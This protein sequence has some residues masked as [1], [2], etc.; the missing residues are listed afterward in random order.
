VK[1]VYSFCSNQRAA[2]AFDDFCL[3]IT[4]IIQLGLPQGLPFLPIL[5][6]LF[7]SDLLIGTINVVEGDMGFVDDYTA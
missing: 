3:E 6:I 1:W 7:N 5:Y 4:N 2:I